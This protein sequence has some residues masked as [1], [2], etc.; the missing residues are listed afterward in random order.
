MGPTN[1]QTISSLEKYN[2]T[3][4]SSHRKFGCPWQNRWHDIY[5]IAASVLP[6]V[7]YPVHANIFI[8]TMTPIDPHRG[9]YFTFSPTSVKSPFGNIS[10]SASKH[11]SCTA[12]QYR[13]VSNGRPK[14]IFS[15]IVA[16]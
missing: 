7:K 10:R 9:I 5:S 12:F 8:S 2:N 11:A 14:H 3:L 16:F 4:L 1:Q 15:R 13:S 6:K